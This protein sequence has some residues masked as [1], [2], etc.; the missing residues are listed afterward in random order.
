MNLRDEILTGPKAAQCAPFI[1]TN[2]MPK[3]PDYLA[4]DQA[5]AD[6]L[7]QDRPAKIT[8]KEV[9]DGLISLALG[10]P[11][12]PIFLYQLKRIATTVLPD[13]ASLEQIAPI[14]V[15]QQAVESLK[16]GAFDVGDDSV[17]AG[18]DM[19]V[20]LLLT[21]EQAGAIKALAEVPD[22][23]SAADV[24]RALRGPWE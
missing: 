10:M 22:V 12:G 7:N 24:S 15:A 18:I 8:R 11:A 16:K 1:V 13:D 9:G 2:E 17:R 3:D 14:A 5:I 21:A 23:V 20:G 6:I 4:K 19:F